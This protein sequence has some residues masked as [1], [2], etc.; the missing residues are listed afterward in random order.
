M[1]VP[2]DAL[3]F[4]SS[5]SWR[6][7]HI[8]WP[9][10]YHFW[11][12]SINQSVG[13]STMHESI[14]SHELGP[15][16]LAWMKKRDKRKHSIMVALYTSVAIFYTFSAAPF[17]KS[18]LFVLRGWKVGSVGR[19]LPLTSSQ[20]NP[21]QMCRKNKQW[22]IKTYWLPPEHGHSFF[23]FLNPAFDD[24]GRQSLDFLRR[25]SPGLR[26]ELGF[27]SAGKRW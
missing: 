13:S 8:Y 4:T 5:V 15:S 25:R 23:F 18:L 16:L 10:W 17:K 22:L 24:R 12:K 2:G 3:Q 27:R 19:R 6:H 9:L 26:S 20:A 14:E 11:N 21:V 7:I 1:C